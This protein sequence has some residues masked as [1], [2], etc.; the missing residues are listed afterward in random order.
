[1]SFLP[2][3][4]IQFQFERAFPQCAYVCLR[5]LPMHLKPVVMLQ[6]P[7]HSASVTGSTASPQFS[8]N[9]FHF[10][11]LEGKTTLHPLAR[12]LL[13]A[14]VT[15]LPLSLF[16]NCQTHTRSFVN[17]HPRVSEGY[18]SKGKIAFR[19]VDCAMNKCRWGYF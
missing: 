8:A 18:V 17:R 10:L 2:L 4:L 15:T 14:S 9:K 12:L 11:C 1:M 5:V 3:L 19:C 13:S 16:Y 6:A 7:T